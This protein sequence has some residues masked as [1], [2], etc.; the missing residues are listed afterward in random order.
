MS[1]EK[2]TQL[3]Q[4]W[5]MLD[6]INRQAFFLTTQTFPYGIKLPLQK[7]NFS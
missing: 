7:L 6:V 3:T 5:H 2:R 1:L 4:I